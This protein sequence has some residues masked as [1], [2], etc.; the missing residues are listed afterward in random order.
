MKQNRLYVATGTYSHKDYKIKES[1]IWLLENGEKRL[2]A[3]R[4]C[5]VVAFCS[6]KGVLYDASNNNVFRTLADNGGKSPISRRRSEVAGLYSH[7]GVLYGFGGRSIFR[8]PE[9][10]ECEDMENALDGMSGFISNFHN[11]NGH[12]YITLESFTF[13]S[14]WDI[15]DKG[16]LLRLADGKSEEIDVCPHSFIG[17]LHSHQ[18]E[19][20][21]TI[22]NE[23][24]KIPR[25]SAFPLAVRERY[26][27]SLCSH[28]GVLYDA[29]SGGKVFRTLEDSKG[30]NPIVERE[31]WISILCSHDNKLYDVCCSRLSMTLEDELA[32]DF[33]EKITA[34]ISHKEE[35]E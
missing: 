35:A 16:I 13:Y 26:I 12:F 4:P 2:V 25:E 14:D 19:L 22:S 3:E 1:R 30:K 23:I 10:E 9:N 34:I 29:S 18:G 24:F 21:C 5:R 11:H 27:A 20:Y 28:K 15:G 33:G 17:N 32:Y 31:D 8:I 6:H 7:N